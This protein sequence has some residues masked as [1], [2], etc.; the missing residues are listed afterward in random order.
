MAAI[1][2]DGDLKDLTETC[3]P[4]VAEEWRANMENIGFTERTFTVDEV[5]VDGSKVAILWTIAGRHT[6]DF[7]GI[8]PTGKRTSN[9]GSAFFT[10]HDGKIAELVTHYDAEGV[11]RQLGATITPTV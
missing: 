3:V 5:V 11:F 1:E 7:A 10:L 9:T 4:S 2:S 6:G 8:P